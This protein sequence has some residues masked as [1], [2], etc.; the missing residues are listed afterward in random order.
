MPFSGVSN[1]KSSH[2][3]LTR[4]YLVLCSVSFRT[5]AV[6]CMCYI[7]RWN[8]LI[9]YVCSLDHLMIPVKWYF[10]VLNLYKDILLIKGV[11]GN[12]VIPIYFIIW[13][14]NS[15]TSYQLQFSKSAVCTFKYIGTHLMNEHPMQRINMSHFVLT[16]GCIK[17]ANRFDGLKYRV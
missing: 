12:L 6:I 14:V 5:N 3:C 2:A 8:I 17:L 1:V 15:V 4:F 9:D 11:T 10:T 13:K 16:I 7:T